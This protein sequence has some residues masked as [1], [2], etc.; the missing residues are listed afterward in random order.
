LT[1]NLVISILLRKVSQ[2]TPKNNIGGGQVFN[3]W[4]PKENNNFKAEYNKLLERHKKAIIYLDDNSIPIREREKYIPHLQEI[5]E[6]LNKLLSEIGTYTQEEVI[7][8]F[9]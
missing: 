3:I 5:I 7:N 2:V 6:R 9:K 8:G 1:C 4:S